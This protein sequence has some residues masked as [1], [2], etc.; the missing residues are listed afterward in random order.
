MLVYLYK[1]QDLGTVLRYCSLDFILK[2]L[3]FG[4]FSH[5]IEVYFLV[6]WPHD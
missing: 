3:S 5:V 2:I 4:F 1:K 6:K